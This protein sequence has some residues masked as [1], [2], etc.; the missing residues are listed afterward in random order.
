VLARSLAPGPG[1]YDTSS[2]SSVN[3]HDRKL[4]KAA[5]G[6]NRRGRSSRDHR[7]SWTGIDDQLTDAG[8]GAYD[9]VHS[10]LFAVRNNRN[11]GFGA[12]PRF[13]ENKAQDVSIDFST[14][15]K[16]QCELAPSDL[17]KA[18][19]VEKRPKVSESEHDRGGSR[20]DRDTA[21]YY[22]QPG[23]GTATCRN[24]SDSVGPTRYSDG[25]YRDSIYRSE[26]NRN[27]MVKASFNNKIAHSNRYQQLVKENY[28]KLAPEKS[29]SNRSAR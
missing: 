28:Q 23:S 27:G 16:P 3:A 15:T 22:R 19:A 26:K 13:Q 1:L 5:S 11:S 12:T 21:W 17:C 20:L 7:A 24:T 8:P 14:R 9:G 2:K 4:R 29:W 6:D 18:G 25:D 10:N